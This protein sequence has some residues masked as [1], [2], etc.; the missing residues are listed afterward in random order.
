MKA[1][2]FRSYHVSAPCDACGKRAE[3]VHMP[4]NEPGFYCALH[5]SEC[6]ESGKAAGSGEG[7]VESSGVSGPEP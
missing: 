2:C 1:N 7:G 3:P 6:N 4:I 5:C